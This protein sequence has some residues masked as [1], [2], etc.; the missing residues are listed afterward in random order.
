MEN[1]P[2]LGPLLPEDALLLQAII[3]MTDPKVVVE[4][5]T[6]RGTSGGK[7]LEALDADAK[8]ISYDNTLSS[9]PSHLSLDQRF[10]FVPKSQDEFE[11]IENIDL[12]Y[13]DASHDLEINKK[14]FKQILPC[15]N[16]LAIVVIHDT[17]V[18]AKNWWNRTVG[19]EMVDGSWAHC[20]DERKFV[21]WIKGEYPDFQ[22][23]HFHSVTKVR[24]GITIL[25]RYNKLK[26][27]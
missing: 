14:T 10:T 25:Q 18:W 8:F 12:V 23:I 19:Y 6:H 26:E 21:N 20:P 7:I 27:I 2:E 4:F 9:A 16:P 24:H 13:I 11:P 3:K 17:G 5:G 22:Q 15:L 1:L